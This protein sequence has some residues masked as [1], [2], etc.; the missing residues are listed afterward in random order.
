MNLTDI[1]ASWEQAQA[2]PQGA[3]QFSEALGQMAP[4]S[5]SVNPLVEKLE[6]GQA[7]V[8][9][10]DQ[11]S[12]RN[13]LQSVHAIALMNLGELATGLALLSSLPAHAKGIITDLGMSY[14]KK[15]RGTITAECEWQP[16]EFSVGDHV[17]R[18]E[19]ILTDSD[20]EEVA[21]A[22]AEWRVRCE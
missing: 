11:P 15:A 6:R 17:C 14:G 9:I 5:G 2:H 20:N 22:R 7:R 8:S 19:A 16:P 12:V 18:L 10:E 13:H 1:L 21:R 4:Y 3:K